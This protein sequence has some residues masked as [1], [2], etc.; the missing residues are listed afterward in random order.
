M[1]VFANCFERGATDKRRVE[2]KVVGK[3]GQDG[4]DMIKWDE[5]GYRN[6]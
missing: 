6:I 3:I 5:M 2:T 4:M 1:E